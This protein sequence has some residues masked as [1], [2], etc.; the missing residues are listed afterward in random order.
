MGKSEAAGLNREYHIQFE[1]NARE[2]CSS[3]NWNPISGQ[4]PRRA[5]GLALDAVLRWLGDALH[6]A[7]DRGAHGEGGRGWGHDNANVDC[8]DPD[9]N[10]TGYEE[11]EQNTFRVLARASDYL[12]PLLER[13]D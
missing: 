9:E 4:E 5:R 6:I 2:A 8:D 7:Q 10:R 13:K 11:A 12:V 3:T 1:Q